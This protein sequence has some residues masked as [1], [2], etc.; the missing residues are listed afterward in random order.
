MKAE[1]DI[2]ILNLTNQS[3]MEVDEVYGITDVKAC[4]ILYGRF[5]ILGNKRFK[6][7]GVYLL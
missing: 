4:V 5:F 2:L 6:N 3:K 1:N 7:K